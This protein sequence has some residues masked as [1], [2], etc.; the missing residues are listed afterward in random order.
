MSAVPIYSC[1]RLTELFTCAESGASQ[2][3]ALSDDEWL[4]WYRL[5]PAER[6][7]ESQKLWATYLMLG[8]SLDPEPDIQSPF[9]DAEASSQSVAHG[10]AGLRVVRRSGI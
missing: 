5:S 2:A 4:D 10:R 1:A 3:G 8:G 6:W 9:Y 7:E